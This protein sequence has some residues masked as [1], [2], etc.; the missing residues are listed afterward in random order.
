MIVVSEETLKGGHKVNELRQEKGLSILDIHRIDL[1]EDPQA[2]EDE[3]NKIS[4]SSL[5]KRLLGTLLKPPKVS[6]SYSSVIGISKIV[7]YFRA[8][9]SPT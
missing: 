4:S 8:R 7:H 3:E 1:V 5:R 9:P 2:D 6:T